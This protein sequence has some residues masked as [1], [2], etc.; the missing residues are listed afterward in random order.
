MISAGNEL[1]QNIANKR[2]IAALAYPWKCSDHEVVTLAFWAPA[3]R[4][5]RHQAKCFEAQTKSK[6]D[7]SSIVSK[8]VFVPMPVALAVAVANQLSTGTG[9]AVAVAVEVE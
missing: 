2:P 9:V 6:Q 5:S 1:G 8:I 3:T 7:I 4:A